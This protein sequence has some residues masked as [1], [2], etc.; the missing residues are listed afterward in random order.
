MDVGVGVK[1]Y[2]V[3]EQ[4]KIGQILSSK[5]TDRRQL[6]EEA[7]GVTK[8]KSRRRQA[9]LK[10]E[11]A[12]QNLTRVDDL[13][14]ELERQRARAQAPG[15]KARRYKRLREEL[16]RWEK[17]LFA[18]RY[19]RLDRGDPRRARSARRGAR[20]RELA[21]ARLAEVESDLERVRIELA[22]ADARR[23]RAARRGAPARARERA[24]PAADRVRHAAGAVARADGAG[25]RRRARL[26]EARRGP[27]RRSS[28]RGATAAQAAERRAR[29]RR[30]GAARRDARRRGARG[31][32][33]HARS[34]RRNGRAAAPPPTC[35][36]RRRCST[37]SSA[38]RKGAI[39][40]AAS[41]AASTSRR[42]TCA[43]RPSAWRAERAQAHEA[44][45]AAQAALEDTVGRA[46]GRRLGAGTARIERDWRQRDARALE[47]SRR[48]RGRA[49]ELARG[50][51]GHP[52]RLRRSGAPGAGS[53]EGGPHAS[54]LGRRLSRSRA[55][56]R[57]RRRSGASAICCST[58]SS[59]RREDAERGLAFVRERN[60]G[61]CGFLSAD[62][63][64][65]GA[66]RA[67]SRRSPARSRSPPRCA[68]S[69]RTTAADPLG[70]RRGLDRRR[71][72]TTARR[73]RAS[74]GHGRDPSG[75]VFRGGRLVIG[76]IRDDGHGILDNEARDPRAG[77]RADQR[78][79]ALETLQTEIADLERA[80]AT[81]P[82]A[83][84]PRQRASSPGEGDPAARAAR[85][86]RRRGARS[87]GAP[88]GARPQRARRA[89]RKSA[90][91]ST[92]APRK[93][94]RHRASGRRARV[95]EARLAT[96]HQV[97]GARREALGAASRRAAEARRRAGRARR[98]RVG[99]RHRRARL[100]ERRA[101][102][103]PA[104]RRAARSA[105]GSTSAA[106]I[107]NSG[108]REPRISSTRIWWPSTSCASACRRRRARRR[109]A[110][111]FPGG[112]AGHA[113]GPRRAR[114]GT[115]RSVALEVACATA[116]SDLA[117]LG[118]PATRRSR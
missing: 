56:P 58:S 55:R 60:A 117:H 88:R 103:T 41:S 102:S 49:P 107:S 29:R 32:D 93:R 36:R 51:R 22:E 59:T 109:A 115:R 95:I 112:G 35:S 61:R 19:E 84:R 113:R 54:R 31:R 65:A 81:T 105:P 72:S 43:S 83:C 71:P 18:Q 24:P 114:R 62:G 33:R 34:A 73:S 92:C 12:Q 21:A 13:I 40:S 39:A 68:S 30:R 57:A 6:I 94:A 14:Y 91:C 67:R 8:F 100:E 28:R 66:E 85:R 53:P 97:L 63:E 9:E 50:A 46:P 27:A 20:A 116:E 10:L 104:S 98:A 38:P 15:G 87:A 108:R 5:P 26:L 101:S 96:A 44:L 1:G 118:P 7:A 111:G 48:R 4:G 25:D 17:L 2:A 89:T 37:R 69:A 3:I 110:G 80:I 75:D 79:R 23:Q 90:A 70:A 77:R 42:T 106:S 64:R 11:A 82:S 74:A 52:R 86:A 47:T 45:R 16:R 76:G 99:A 78:A